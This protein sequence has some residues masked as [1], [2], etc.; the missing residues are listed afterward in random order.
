ME[1]FLTGDIWKQV[2][3]LIAKSQSKIACIAYVTSGN[4]QLTKGD[5]LICDAS[6]YEIKFGATSAKILDGY[7]RKGVEILSNQN[8]HSKLL[9]TNSFLVVGSANLSN[10]SAETLVE[11]AVITDND[12]LLSQAKAFCHNLIKESIPL[13]RKDLDRKLKIKVVKRE[14]KPSKV[15]ATRK[16][17]FGSRYWFVSLHEMTERQS[18]KV[19]DR[20]NTAK[21]KAIA[22]TKYSAEELGSIFYRKQN[23]FSSLAKEGDQILI[24]WVDTKRTGKF[25]FEFSTILQIDR[26]GE[27]AIF[28]HDDSS[29]NGF[30]LAQFIKKAKKLDLEKA[31]DKIRTRVLSANDALKL[32]TLWHNK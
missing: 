8:L 7:F 31:V 21:E 22:K 2:D 28:I 15:S 18:A 17:L 27:E 6:E 4:L 24:K 10:R 20:I 9:L 3:T 16:K 1:Q 29:E 14:F 23:K 32:K 13:S 11:S 30:T 12:I 5:I 25:V 19:D 26:S